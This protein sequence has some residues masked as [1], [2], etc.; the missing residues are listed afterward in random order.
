M[1]IKCSGDIM[2]KQSRVLMTDEQYEAIALAASKKGMPLAT[3]LRSLALAEAER[4]GINV[5]QPQVD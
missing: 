5:K 4:M 1:Q 3:F 2:E